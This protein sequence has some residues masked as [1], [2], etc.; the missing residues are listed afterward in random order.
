MLFFS[1][2]AS[3]GLSC[4]EII[5]PSR[6]KKTLGAATLVAGGS[7][8][9]LKVSAPQLAELKERIK[10]R[11]KVEERTKLKKKKLCGE[12]LSRTKIVKIKDEKTKLRNKD[13]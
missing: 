9:L 13:Y 6:R 12:D 4:R 11:L 8:P 7:C 1:L 5:G 10:R 3:I 2:F